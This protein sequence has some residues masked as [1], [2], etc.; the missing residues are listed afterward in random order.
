MRDGRFL[1]IRGRGDC[2]VFR[3]IFL[4]NDY[5]LKDDFYFKTV[6]DVGAHVGIFTVFVSP[7]AERILAIEPEPENLAVFECNVKLNGLEEK[8]QIIPC[9][10]S[11]KDGVAT[12]FRYSDRQDAHTLLPVKKNNFDT[13]SQ[14]KTISLGTLFRN[15]NLV[16]CDLLKLDCEGLEYNIIFKTPQEVWKKVKAITME[17][18]P[19]PERNVWDLKKRLEELGFKVHLFKYRPPGYGLVRAWKEDSPFEH[20]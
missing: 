8:V 19:H 4:R 12:L 5:G 13:K 17:T 11:Y 6:I 15:Y 18:H 9:A 14:I 3:D 16:H 7:R 10:L 2:T 1:F 20:V